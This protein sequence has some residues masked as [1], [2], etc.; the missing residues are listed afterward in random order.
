MHLSPAVVHKNTPRPKEHQHFQYQH[1]LRDAAW[2]E[3]RLVVGLATHCL[4]GSLGS[5]LVPSVVILLVPG[6][7]V[8]TSSAKLNDRTFVA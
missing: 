5:I 2:L 6:S 7:D 8:S 4:S 1:L 3:R